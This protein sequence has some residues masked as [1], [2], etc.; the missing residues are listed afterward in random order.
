VLFADL[1]ISLLSSLVA[2]VAGP[3]SSSSARVWFPIVVSVGLIYWS[4]QRG[5]KEL[6]S[7]LASS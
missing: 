6:G 3:R 2:P 1:V 7:I 5:L 4:G